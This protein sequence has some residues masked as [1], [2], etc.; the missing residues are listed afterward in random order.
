MLAN[1]LVS[2]R[3]LLLAVWLAWLA[4][5]IWNWLVFRLSI[6]HPPWQP[7]VLLVAIQ[8]AA[9]VLLAIGCGAQYW[10]G[11]ERRAALG[12]LLLGISPLWLWAALVSY[13][14]WTAGNGYFPFNIL[15]AEGAGIGASIGDLEARLR[16][17]DR[18]EGERAVMFHRGW[19]QAAE[20]VAAIDRHLERLEG[21][22][23]QPA[24]GK[25]HWIRGPLWGRS[26]YYFQG[27]ATSEPAEPPPNS[28]DGLTTVDRHELAHFAIEQL[29]DH[30]HRPPFVLVEGW[31][32]AQSGYEP[33]HLA[34]QAM[35]ARERGADLSLAELTGGDW[36][37][38]DLGPVYTHGGALVDYLLCAYGGPKF[39]ELYTT[40]RPAT[41]AADVRRVLGVDLEQL[42]RDYWAD[43]ERQCP[44]WHLRLQRAL[45]ELAL[46]EGVGV[47]TYRTFAREYPAICATCEPPPSGVC[48]VTVVYEN[49]DGKR[50][51]QRDEHRMEIIHAGARQ[52][53]ISR[54]P[55]ADEVV[56]AGPQESFW[57]RRE[58]GQSLWRDRSGRFA[59]LARLQCLEDISERGW[60]WERNPTAF[61]EQDVTEFERRQWRISACQ[62]M[63]RREQEIVQITLKRITPVLAEVNE[64]SY[65]FLP[66][67]GW[68]FDGSE[69]AKLGSDGVTTR[70]QSQMLYRFS[71]GAPPVQLGAELV[72]FADASG[73]LL[74]RAEHRFVRRDLDERARQSLQLSSYPL[75]RQSA[76]LVLPVP[77]SVAI[78]WAGAGLSLVLG[79]ALRTWT[80][81]GRRRGDDNGPAV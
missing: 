1:R 26:G 46:A 22:L 68:A 21:V 7:L 36:Y 56:V 45:E 65:R 44:R 74:R 80:F 5:V 27:L 48:E 16:Y 60:D 14:L 42:D 3:G 62:R 30:T 6:L 40:C 78:T 70:Q 52:G 76:L 63:M 23:G 67:H 37:C 43:V 10:R 39:L 50:Q 24:R 51:P 20:Q 11:T 77:A 34:R 58:Q 17:P 47:E 66:A 69:S 75:A 18:C 79:I 4:I 59:P 54:W 19:P 2:I 28:R 8:I 29:C 55:F 35:R 13:V 71:P 32:E 53:V 49:H 25:A 15:L 38:R 33:G 73:E 72:S 61:T 31:A 64:R 81:V 41:F 57:L 9:T 12:S